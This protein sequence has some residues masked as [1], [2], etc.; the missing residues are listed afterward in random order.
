MPSITVN[1]HIRD[2]AREFKKQLATKYGR[3]VY[4]DEVMQRLFEDHEKLDEID[5][6][7]NRLRAVIEDIAK[8]P[9]TVTAVGGGGGIP[10]MTPAPP[11]SFP[12][13]TR[14]PGSPPPASAPVPGFKPPT[15]KPPDGFPAGDKLR[16][17]LMSE[18]H[19]LF[20]DGPPKLKSAAEAMR[21]E[22]E[23]GIAE[24]LEKA[25]KVA[26]E[27]LNPETV[28]GIMK[29][30]GSGDDRL[31]MET[32]DLLSSI[33]RVMDNPESIVDGELFDHARD[34]AIL[35][36]EMTERQQHD[37]W[38]AK[39]NEARD[40]IKRIMQIKKGKEE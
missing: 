15:A 10:M 34:V 26:G 14:P 25:S 27:L 23:N 20:K 18:M 13:G 36:E 4:W 39:I 22:E 35:R 9:L 17:D 5:G 19:K 3:R 37:E 28:M 21:E 30:C 1:E 38:E 8:R 31:V 29:A 6:E 33:K 32:K 24:Q 12:P 16:S 11:P 2:K 40:V 7:I